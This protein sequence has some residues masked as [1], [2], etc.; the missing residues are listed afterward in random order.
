MADGC[1]EKLDWNYIKVM[2]RRDERK[3]I[4]NTIL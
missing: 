4:E 3:E 1:I 2:W